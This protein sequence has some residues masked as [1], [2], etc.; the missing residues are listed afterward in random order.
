V[1]DRVVVVLGCA[2][3]EDGRPSAF[4]HDRLTTAAALVLRGAADRVIASG[5][6]EAPAMGDFLAEAG[7]A[8]VVV[9]AGGVRTIESFRRARDVFALDACTVVTH[10]YHLPRAL[11]LARRF[12][13]AATG[14]A[15]VEDRTA[16]VRRRTVWKN[17]AREVGAWARAIADVTVLAPPRPRS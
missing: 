16:S 6:P 10:A 4:L 1:S 7:V 2:L 13:I 14:V 8:D 9:D 17:R 12:G 3:G 15:A 11:F 5:G